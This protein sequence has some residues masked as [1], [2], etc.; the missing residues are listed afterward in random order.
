MAFLH[1]LVSALFYIGVVF[2]IIFAIMAAKPDLLKDKKGGLKVKTK[3]L[4][5][6]DMTAAT[7]VSALIVFVG[8]GNVMAATGK[9]V[10]QQREERAAAQQLQEKQKAEEAERERLRKIEAAKPK[11]ETEIKRD[12]I[13]YD[14]IEQEDDSIPRGETRVATEGVEGVRAITYEVTYVNGKETDRKEIS[15]DVTVEPITK[16]VLVGTYV[17]PPPV[18]E[19]PPSS[20]SGYVNSQGNFVPSPSSNPEGATA[21][22]RNGT[23]SYSQSRRGTCSHHGGVAEWL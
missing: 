11:V 20:G 13:P 17:A 1:F 5:R 14:T 10:E 12:A 8:F 4:T 3:P 23:Y 16:V 18:V 6:R 21:K 7:L 2:V 9:G 22:C 19:A 15:N